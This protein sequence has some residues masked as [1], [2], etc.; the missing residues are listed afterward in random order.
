MQL[1]PLPNDNILDWSKIKPFIDIEFHV[2]HNY[3]AMF[4]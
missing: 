2:A 4:L 1:F 3:D